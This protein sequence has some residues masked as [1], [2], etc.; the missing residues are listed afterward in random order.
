LNAA[1]LFSGAQKT[2]TKAK[3][4]SVHFS[5]VEFAS[6][7]FKRFLFEKIKKKTK[8]TSTNGCGSQS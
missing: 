2:K 4:G 8:S 5:S 1:H 3:Y 6:D 7:R